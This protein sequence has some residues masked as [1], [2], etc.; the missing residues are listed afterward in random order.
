MYPPG[1]MK[2]RQPRGQQTRGPKKGIPG[3]FPTKGITPCQAPFLNPGPPEGAFQ[4]K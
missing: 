1:G 4:E 2:N 3:P